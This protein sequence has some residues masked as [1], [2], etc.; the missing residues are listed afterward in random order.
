M[1]FLLSPLGSDKCYFGKDG[2]KLWAPKNVCAVVKAYQQQ[3]LCSNSHVQI[4]VV[5]FIF[6]ADGVCISPCIY[7]EEPIKVDLM[8]LCLQKLVFQ[9]CFCELI[10]RLGCT[11][12]PPSWVLKHG[13]REKGF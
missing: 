9:V 2:N 5:V 10:F 1:V 4:L 11:R 13:L 12:L 3:L 6:K 8:V 7:E